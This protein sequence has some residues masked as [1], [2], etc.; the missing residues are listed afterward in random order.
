LDYAFPSYKGRLLYTGDVG[1]IFG[2]PPAF[3]HGRRVMSGMCRSGKVDKEF[4]RIETSGINKKRF[5]GPAG[6]PHP[7]PRRLEHV[8][9]LVNQFSDK[10]VVDPFMGSGTT[11]VASKYLNRKFIGIEIE[12]RFCALAV[13]RLSQAVMDLS[14]SGKLRQEFSRVDL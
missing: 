5:T 11:A 12:E 10:Q 2:I 9:W 7:C 1:Y 3:I 13:K 4:S 6:L 14:P 8:K